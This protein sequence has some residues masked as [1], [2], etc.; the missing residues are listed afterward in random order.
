MHQLDIS[1]ISRWNCHKNNDNSVAFTNGN[2]N[3]AKSKYTAFC[4][5]IFL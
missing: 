1:N 5:A 2:I 4:A 3:D